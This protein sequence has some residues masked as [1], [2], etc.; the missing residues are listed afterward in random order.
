MDH[1]VLT[2]GGGPDKM[3]DRFPID[4]EAGLSVPNHHTT[5]HID[6]E[7]ITQVALLRLAVGTLLAFASEDREDMVTRHQLGHTLSDAL[8]NAVRK[9][10][11]VEGVIRIVKL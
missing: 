8:N 7:K 11:F 10:S 6:P 3:E 9:I 4:G 2:E 1:G 5:I